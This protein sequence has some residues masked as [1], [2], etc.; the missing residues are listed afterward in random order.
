MPA[1]YAAS[2][3]MQRVIKRNEEQMQLIL[4]RDADPTDREF[5][6]RSLRNYPMHWRTDDL[7]KMVTD[8]TDNES[9]RIVMAEALGWFCH[10]VEREKIAAT[11][12]DCLAR[13]KSLSP[14][15]RREMAKAVKRIQGK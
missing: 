14:R 9:L 7:L 4:D 15:L 3:R 13:D 1:D 6:I 10:S 8:P 12:S 2:K 11:L 5:A